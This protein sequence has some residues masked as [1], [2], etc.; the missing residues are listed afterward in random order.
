[1]CSLICSSDVVAAIAVVKY[2]NQPKLFS[3]IFGEG[4]TNDAVGIILFN[5][6]IQYTKP[7]EHL[8]WVTPLKILGDFIY[9]LFSSIMIGAFFGLI[10]ALMFKYSRL[11]TRSAIVECSLVF[12]FAYASYLVAELFSLSGIVTL[13]SCGIF[14]GQYTWFNLSPQAKQAT[15]FSFQLISYMLEAFIFAYLGLGVF[16]FISFDWSWKL[17]LAMFAIILV[18]RT[19]ATIGI[20]KFLE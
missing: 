5:T 14:M 8:D 2:E 13:L 10:S 15:S 7:S 20:I 11:L 3:V 4:I 16:S 18:M 17:F 12:S 6:V 19:I 9:L 1:M